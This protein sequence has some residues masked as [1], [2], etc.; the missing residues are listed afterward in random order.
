MI[1]D[2]CGANVESGADFC[3]ACGNK[4][5]NNAVD[6]VVNNDE[7]LDE[8]LLDKYKNNINFFNLSDSNGIQKS[9]V[10]NNSDLNVLPDF[11]QNIDNQTVLVQ[12]E[13]INE[14]I[15][16]ENSIQQDNPILGND[17][18]NNVNNENPYFISDN[19]LNE[20]QTDLNSPVFENNLNENPVDIDE[21]VF[22]NVSDNLSGEQ[23]NLTQEF[24]GN[25]D[26]YISPV[27]EMNTEQGVQNTNLA[28]ELEVNQ[29]PYVSPLN[30]EMNT[31]QGV[32]SVGV[33][34][35]VTI[36]EAPTFT[37]V[38]AV[39]P[40]EPLA[41]P[42]NTEP[43]KE[44][45][46]AGNKNDKPKKKVNN[47]LIVFIAVAFIALIVIVIFLTRTDSKTVSCIQSDTDNGVTTEKVLIASF[48]NNKIKSL[49]ISGSYVV[50]S[51]Y[52]QY[53][54][55]FYESKNEELKK[56]DGI[57]GIDVTVNKDSNTITYSVESGDASTLA[58]TELKATADVAD[59]F[60]NAAEEQGYKCTVTKD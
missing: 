16:P 29:N 42:V 54:D 18:F 41:Q 57:K 36:E 60:I 44:N 56:Y 4:I 19:V 48:K 20:N 23:T 37:N 27:N 33:A 31:E 59:N 45:S 35:D 3:W 6:N 25:Q 58:K 21:P 14:P 9:E 51:N 5:E 22:T 50:G 1:C 47:N 17:N 10:E 15:F 34:P 28:Q 40:E 26:S 39:T 43:K 32:Q 38:S 49:L 46:D 11:S 53:M 7:N 12:S 52:M 13:L 55:S 8:N 30:N 24:N 2:K